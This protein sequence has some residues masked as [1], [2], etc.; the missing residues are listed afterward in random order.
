M[1]GVAVDPQGG[2]LTALDVRDAISEDVT[3]VFG[4]YFLMSLVCVFDRVV[5]GV[6][7]VE[8]HPSLEEGIVC[9]FWGRGGD[10]ICKGPG[11]DEGGVAR[12]VGG[13]EH[14]VPYFL[15]RVHPGGIVVEGRETL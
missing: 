9:W 1:E 10:S 2:M 14:V 13:P 7:G 12:A 11:V 8:K 3:D 15:K 5:V 4:R 6:T